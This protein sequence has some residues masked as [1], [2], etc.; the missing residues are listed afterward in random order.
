MTHRDRLPLNSHHLAGLLSN[1][2]QTAAITFRSSTDG[3]LA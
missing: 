2:S 1:F 3:Q